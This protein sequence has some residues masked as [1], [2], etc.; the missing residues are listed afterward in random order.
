M[1]EILVVGE[2]GETLGLGLL[3]LATFAPGDDPEASIRALPAEKIGVVLV[4]ARFN[5]RHGAV[6]DLLR[7]ALP[8]AAVSIVPGPRVGDAD[9]LDHLRKATIKA[10]GVDTWGVES[11]RKAGAHR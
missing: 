2:A 6:V 10:L 11:E 5:A 3:G 4:T 7:R 1:P 9:H 8:R